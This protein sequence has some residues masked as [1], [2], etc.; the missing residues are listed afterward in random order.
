MFLISRFCYEKCK[1]QT[2]YF[3]DDGNITLAEYMQFF[4][5]P[6][7][8]AKPI[9]DVYDY[10]GDGV[11]PVTDPQAYFDQI[12]ANGNVFVMEKYTRI[13]NTAPLD[14]HVKLHDSQKYTCTVNN[15]RKL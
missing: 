13:I 2:I 4:Q 6:I 9:F 7:E 15:I 8:V 5:T 12:D 1:I 3:A 14:M 11:I 10:D